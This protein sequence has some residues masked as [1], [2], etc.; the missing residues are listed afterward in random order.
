M[1]K[2]CRHVWC[3]PIPLVRRY[4][5]AARKDTRVSA[6]LCQSCGSC[7]RGVYV[8]GRVPCLC[9]SRRRGAI[10]ERWDTQRHISWFGVLELVLGACFGVGWRW[11]GAV[12]ARIGAAETLPFNGVP[13][14]RRVRVCL[15][16]PRCILRLLQGYKDLFMFEAGR[17][18]A[19]GEGVLQFESSAWTS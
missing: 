8:G 10:R 1:I 2:F 6:A 16:C 7:G 19:S 17:R 11:C 15:A 14:R 13:M 12:A 3:R 9:W 4:A 18:C 5:L